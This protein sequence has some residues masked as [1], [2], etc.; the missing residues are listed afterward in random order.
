[1]TDPSKDP[2]KSSTIDVEQALARP[3]TRGVE[4]VIKWKVTG[5]PSPVAAYRVWVLTGADKID[6][7]TLVVGK[8]PG[9]AIN[10]S[11]SST[12]VKMLPPNVRSIDVLLAP[13]PKVAEQHIGLTE[14]WGQPLELKDVTLERFDR[15]AATT[16]SSP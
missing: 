14:I 2:F 8:M 6:Y 11:S 15:A 10:S 1:V 12:I 5:E 16:A 9:G 4:I 3:A 13:D 7:G